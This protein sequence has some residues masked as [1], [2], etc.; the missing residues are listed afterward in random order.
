MRDRKRGR[1]I[2]VVLL[3]CAALLRLYRVDFK[4]LEADE[5]FTV[6]ISDPHNSVLDVLSIPLHN[7]PQAKPAL[8]FLVTHFFL[9]LED[10]DF[11][12]RFPALAAGVLGV[13]VTYAVGSALFGWKEG[14]AAAFLLCISPLH[15]RYSQWARFYTPLLSLSLLSLFFLWRAITRADLKAWLGFSVVTVLNLYTHLFALLVLAAETLFFTSWWLQSAIGFVRGKRASLHLTG[16]VRHGL[17]VWVS[18][19]SILAL[20]VALTIVTVAYAPMIPHLLASLVGPKGIAEDNET[21]GLEFSLSFFRGLQAEW[22]VGTGVGSMVFLAFFLAGVAVSLR[23]QRRPI[24]L[25]LTWVGVPLAVLFAV[26]LKHRFYPRYLVFLLPVYLV[27]VARGLTAGDDFVRYLLRRISGEKVA[28]SSVGLIA[29]LVLLAGVS[30]RPLSQY[31]LETMSDWS[32][33]ASFLGGSVSSGEPILVRRA[34]FEIALLHYDERLAN[35]E[36]GVLSPQDALLADLPYERGIWFVGKEGRKNEMS[37]LEEALVALTER[38][39]SKWVFEG[40]GDPRLPGAGESMF[41]DVW[42]LYTGSGPDS[43]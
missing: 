3:L 35:V 15:I 13:A 24:A 11:L 27:V 31:Y 1:R 12:L 36:F 21:P 9:R 6:A 37:R 32:R 22:S 33:V 20:L 17:P 30:V 14:L 43:G 42:V 10:H 34:L 16:D 29:G 38:P 25:A 39:V 28:R 2:A 5:I 19:R 23:G 7:S 8:Y 40:Y 26:P 41:W 4:G 18:R